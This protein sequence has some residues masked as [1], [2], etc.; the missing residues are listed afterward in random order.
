MTSMPCVCLYVC[1]CACVFADTCIHTC[2]SQRPMSDVFLSSRKDILLLS[3]WMGVR[4]TDGS[5]EE[6]EPSKAAHS[7]NCF[8]KLDPTSSLPFNY[9][10]TGEVKLVT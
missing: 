5:H 10:L 7:V 6:D 9:G 2:R 3:W 1:V 4:E 8:L